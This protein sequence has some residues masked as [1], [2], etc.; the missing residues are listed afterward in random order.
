MKKKGN[1]YSSIIHVF[2][3]FIAMFCSVFLIKIAS[4]P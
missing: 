2:E 1:K 4:D 3:R